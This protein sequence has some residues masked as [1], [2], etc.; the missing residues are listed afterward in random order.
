M[1][2]VFKYWNGSEWVKCTAE[3]AEKRRG[4]GQRILERQVNADGTVSVPKKAAAPV[5]PAPAKPPVK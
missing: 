1:T 5:P 3:E 4:L 2:N